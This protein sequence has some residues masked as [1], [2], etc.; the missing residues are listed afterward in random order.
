[1][2]AL[3][4][5]VEAESTERIARAA[6]A[7]TGAEEIGALA[8]MRAA[9]TQF[10]EVCLEPD[11]QQIVFLDAPRVLGWQR[12]REVAA[13]HG[14]GLVEQMLALAVERGEIKP[15]PIR[16]MAHILTAALSEAAMVVADAEDQ[17]AALSEAIAALSALLDGLA[18]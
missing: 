18:R 13:E 16:P 6:L 2:D 3:Y 5:T 7:Q 1:M 12:W 9:I 8:M 4:E 11:I 17:E 10:L 15:I 14:L